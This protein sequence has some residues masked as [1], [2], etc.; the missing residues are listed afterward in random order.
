MWDAA[1][2]ENRAGLGRAAHCGDAMTDAARAIREI[3]Q[4]ISARPVFYGV[5]TPEAAALVR[6]ILTKYGL[7]VTQEEGT[8]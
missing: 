5:G 3:G 7:W 2:G 8:R 4:R 6:E 1:H